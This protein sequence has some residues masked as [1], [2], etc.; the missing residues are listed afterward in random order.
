MWKPSV[1]GLN[2]RSAERGE[3]MAS[4]QGI[5][6]RPSQRDA[7]RRLPAASSIATPYDA[8]V[9]QLDRVSASEAE[10][11]GFES[12]RAHFFHRTL[13]IAQVHRN[14]AKSN[15][16]HQTSSG[17][18]TPR[19]GGDRLLGRPRRGEARSAE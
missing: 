4:F 8:P 3:C 12:R 2:P 17:S 15:P 10:G 5:G 18:T 16:R 11:R 19:S 6:G 7:G 13:S 9:A 14:A 1:T